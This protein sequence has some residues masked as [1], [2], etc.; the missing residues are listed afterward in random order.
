[1][2]KLILGQVL[3]WAGFVVGALAT[4]WQAPQEGVKF[5]RSQQQDEAGTDASAGSAEELL[6]EDGWHLISWGWYSGS[7]LVAVI[8]VV[9]IHLGKGE[10]TRKSEQSQFDLA[11]ITDSLDR[12]VD[13]VALITKKVT[14]LPP[15]QVLAQIDDELTDDLRTFA[16]GRDAIT[17]EFGLPVFADVMS[18]FAAGERAV[19]RAW[20]A[21]AD[22]YLN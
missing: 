5:V 19:N 12:L 20:C 2:N 17:A 14:Y 1:M 13:N 10:T 22:G 18:S 16:E 4:V 15:S 6:P 9:L 11:E 8:G 3:L 7:V 21:A